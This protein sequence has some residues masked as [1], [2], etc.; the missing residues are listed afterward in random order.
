MLCTE[1]RTISALVYF[2]TCLVEK[3]L[4]LREGA[5]GFC[6]LGNISSNSLVVGPK[7]IENLDFTFV[8]TVRIS[9]MPKKFRLLISGDR[10]EVLLRGMLL[11]NNQ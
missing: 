8:R 7:G 2:L 11:L 10:D 1:L 6:R 5:G 4:R 3:F 9:P